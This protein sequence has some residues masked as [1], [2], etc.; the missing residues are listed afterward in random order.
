MSNQFLQ[1]LQTLTQQMLFQEVCVFS[2]PLLLACALVLEV[3]TGKSE[4]CIGSIDPHPSP[5][6]HAPLAR[7]AGKG[8]FHVHS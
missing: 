3:P 1:V 6:P 5:L 7:R 8:S 2:L 4:G